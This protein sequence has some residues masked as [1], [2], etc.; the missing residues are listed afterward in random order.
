[1]FIESELIGCWKKYC[2]KLV[3]KV[4]ARRVMGLFGNEESGSKESQFFGKT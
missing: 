3:K 1:M 4:C 2:K